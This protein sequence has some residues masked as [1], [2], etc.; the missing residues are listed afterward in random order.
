MDTYFTTRFEEKLCT[1]FGLTEML[2][3]YVPSATEDCETEALYNTITTG[4]RS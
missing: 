1:D 2:Q 3:K 4:N